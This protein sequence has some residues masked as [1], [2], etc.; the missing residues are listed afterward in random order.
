MNYFL[1]TLLLNNMT[2][3][4]FIFFIYVL[5]TTIVRKHFQPVCG[6]YEIKMGFNISL[7]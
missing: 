7:L 3:Q 6:K 1:L 4:K 2:K 5:G